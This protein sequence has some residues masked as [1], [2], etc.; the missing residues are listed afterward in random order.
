LRPAI[1]SGRVS[2]GESIDRPDAFLDSGFTQVQPRVTIQSPF[3]EAARGE[4]EIDETPQGQGNQCSDQQ[5]HDQHGPFSRT[6]NVG[7]VDEMLGVK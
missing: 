6:R 2:C 1:P 5:R 3:R 7:K 4:V